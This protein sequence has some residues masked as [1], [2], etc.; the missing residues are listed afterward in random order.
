MI[1]TKSTTIVREL[2]D[3]FMFIQVR[4][5]D[6]WDTKDTTKIQRQIHIYHTQTHIELQVFLSL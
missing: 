2:E 6:F 1:K 3:Y 4:E 5:F